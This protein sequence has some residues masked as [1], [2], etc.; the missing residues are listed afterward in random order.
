MVFSHAF[1][2]AKV[3]RWRLVD[4]GRTNVTVICFGEKSTER[5]TNRSPADFDSFAK[6]RDNAS[7]AAVLSSSVP[8]SVV[9]SMWLLLHQRW[10]VRVPPLRV[11]TAAALVHTLRGA[12]F[13]PSLGHRRALQAKHA[14]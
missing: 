13:Q 11:E 14:K 12:V 2:I 7:A 6:A 4:G 3:M 10:R 8:G 9:T 5:I 1:D